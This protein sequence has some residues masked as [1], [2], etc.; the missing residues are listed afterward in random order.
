MYRER[1]RAELTGKVEFDPLKLIMEQLENALKY[2]GTE[3]WPT[4]KKQIEN[5][6]HAVHFGQVVPLEDLKAILDIAWPIARITCACR[7][8]VYGLEDEENFYC[9]GI[10]VGMYK[11]ERWPENYRG[12][13]EFISPDEA[14][15]LVEEFNKKGLVHT[16]WVFGTPYIGGICNCEYPV[17]LGI[18]NRVDY[19]IKILLKGHYVA[20]LD[21]EKCNG[22]RRCVARCQFGAIKYSPSMNKVV[23]DMKKCFGCG[24][25][26]TACPRG[27]IRLERREKF[28]AIANDW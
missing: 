11:W 13:V 23:I 9:F 21:P 20:V 26:V 7:R 27:A 12:G 14:K 22:C 28:P 2:Y 15:R 6:C 3:R 5:F 19:G 25:C 24:L 17:C 4:I 10:G 18:R 1:K 16:I 8:M